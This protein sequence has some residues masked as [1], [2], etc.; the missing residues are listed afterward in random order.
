VTRMAEP[1]SGSLLSGSTAG[2]EQLRAPGLLGCHAPLR[3][4]VQPAGRGARDGAAESEHLT[5]PGRFYRVRVW[6]FS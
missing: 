6:E 2:D 3:T 4:V 1:R 5:P